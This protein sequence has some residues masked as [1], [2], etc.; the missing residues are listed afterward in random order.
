MTITYLYFTIYLRILFELNRTHVMLR[1]Y[2]LKI[3]YGNVPNLNSE[4]CS[5]TIEIIH[6]VSKI[7]RL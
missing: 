4:T 5:T 1:S 2:G 7:N 3:D 6:F